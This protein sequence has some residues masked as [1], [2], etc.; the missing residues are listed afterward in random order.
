M[1]TH[2]GLGQ[3]V[4]LLRPWVFTDATS[5]RLPPDTLMCYLGLATFADH[6]GY[7]HWSVPEIAAR[8]C[9]YAPRAMR[10]KLLDRWAR[11]LQGR[12]LLVILDCGCA[13][14]P[15]MGRDFAQTGGHKATTCYDF[16]ERHHGSGF[17]HTTD[18]PERSGTFQ[19]VAGNGHS[20]SNGYS[21]R[22]RSDVATCVEC[23]QA[24][25][26]G[27]TNLVIVGREQPRHRVCPTPD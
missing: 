9:P 21:N 25:D 7:V 23:G 6:V 17:A 14:L 20:N 27:D 10:E 13:F 24:I 8:L 3:S 16:H 5:G 26:H 1:P 4:R 18:V 12:D 15:R 11:Q 22:P 19:D 2:P